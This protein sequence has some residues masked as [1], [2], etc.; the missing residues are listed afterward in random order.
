MN[1]NEALIALG[2]GKKIRATSWRLTEYIMVQ[3]KHVVTN[4]G[5]LYSLSGSGYTYWE[6]YEEPKPK[7]KYYRRKW[8][9]SGSSV[10]ASCRYYPTREIFDR[11]YL[12]KDEFDS[13]E[14]ETIEI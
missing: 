10:Q 8:V 7:Q 3:G 11:E 13:P 6:L 4:A 14:W 1:L 9:R 12:S 5:K 2:E